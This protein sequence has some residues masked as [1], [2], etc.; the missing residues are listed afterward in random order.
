MKRRFYIADPNRAMQHYDELQI[1]LRKE[2]PNFP[3]IHNV[4]ALVP[5]PLVALTSLDDMAGGLAFIA[6]KSPL[7]PERALWI[8]GIWVVPEYRRQGVGSQLIRAAQQEAV[9]AGIRQLYALT[10]LPVL[11]SN[12]SWSIA[13]SAGTDFVMEWNADDEA[14][15]RGN[16]G[17]PISDVAKR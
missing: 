5:K 13:S 16:G 9:R 17:A 1:R 7:G 10:E 4:E 11:Y 2:W 12:L 8:N 14:A 3:A 15:A 6:A